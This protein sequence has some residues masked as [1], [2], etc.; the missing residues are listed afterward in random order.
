[1]V[2]SMAIGALYADNIAIMTESSQLM[3]YG[4]TNLC[5][6]MTTEDFLKSRPAAKRD[7]WLKEASL[8]TGREYY[9]ERFTHEPWDTGRFVMISGQLRRV[10]LVR[11]LKFDDPSIKD[12]RSAFLLGCIQRW[13]TNCTLHVRSTQNY[14]MPVLRW[15]RDGIK[16]FV[17]M[18][19]DGIK[20]EEQPIFL[21]VVLA[22]TNN[23]KAD[24]IIGT[25]PLDADAVSEFF[26]SKAPA[27]LHLIG[28]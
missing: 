19:P 1:M 11:S 8:V 15:E 5:F 18:P 26:Q 21:Q 27:I 22:D 16:V 2:A 28:R 14:Q 20:D 10:S 13:G 17:T 25:M 12:K 3:P 6:G 9:D 23:T 24:E 7:E 4:F